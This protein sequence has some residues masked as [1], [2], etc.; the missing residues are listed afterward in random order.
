MTEPDRPRR[1]AE[2]VALII[3]GGI[4]LS[5]LVVTIGVVVVAVLPGPPETLGENATQILTGWG[6]GMIGILGAFIGYAFGKRANG[7]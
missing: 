3:A 2:W 4:S 5:L 1:V 7:G 6:G